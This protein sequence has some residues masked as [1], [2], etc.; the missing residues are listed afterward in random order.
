MALPG[1]I[2]F[3]FA[4]V[5]RASGWQIINDDVMGGVSTSQFEVLDGWA[6]FRGTVSLENSGGFASVR[7]A[8]IDEDLAGYDAFVVRLRGDGK[9][10]KFT[11]RTDPGF[12]V[13]IYQCAFTTKPGEGK[14]LELPCH[15][16]IPSFRGRVLTDLP[17]LDPAK[18]CAVGFII[19]DQQAGIFQLEIASIGVA[20]GHSLGR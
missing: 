10:Y 8:L 15:E 6:V 12:N 3:D 5:A 11:V 17:P 14:E 19:A 7:S 2:L 9:R 4:K 1:K 13:P 20:A 16:F 18:V